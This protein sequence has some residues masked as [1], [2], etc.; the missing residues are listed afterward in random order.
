MESYSSCSPKIEAVFKEAANADYAAHSLRFF[1]T[2]KG[3]YG[4]G[5]L[6]LG[7]RVQVLLLS[8]HLPLLRPGGM[9]IP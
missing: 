8:R 4:E 3:E 2:G 7:I 6:F 5:D 9:L 1:K